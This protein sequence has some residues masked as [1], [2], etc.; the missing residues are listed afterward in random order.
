MG[1]LFSPVIWAY[2]G[3]NTILTLSLYVNFYC[4]QFSLGVAAFMGMG[5]YLSSIL[6]V[7]Y[8]LNINVALLISSTITCAMGV[9][10]A[11][12]A[13]RL[14]GF[15][16]AIATIGLVEIFRVTFKNI[17][18][19][20]GTAG[21][22]GMVGTTLPL[23]YIWVAFCLVLTWKLEHSRLGWAMRAIHQDETVAQI[24]GLNS[25][26]L[27]IISFAISA[28]LA[29]LGGGLYAH[30]MFYIDPDAFGIHRSLLILLFLVF[31]GQTMW[32][33]LIG[34]PVLTILPEMI[35]QIGELRLVFYGAILVLIMNIRP[36][37]IVP[38]VLVRRIQHRIFPSATIAGNA[39]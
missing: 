26:Y 8:Q 36:Q 20:G 3:I 33:V 9:L 2:V 38:E 11:F 5:A 34:V 29:A 13:L 28:F 10:L 27:K 21:F 32:G 7:K 1:A 19:I 6:T 23:I 31:G 25:T 12:P 37:G 35:P 15:Y 22:S 17:A 30:Y 39:R 24:M 18:F 14:R 4:G 16:L